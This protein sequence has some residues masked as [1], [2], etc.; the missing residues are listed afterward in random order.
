MNKEEKIKEVLGIVGLAIDPFEVAAF[1][2]EQHPFDDK[3]HRMSFL[4]K[5]GKIVKTS[6]M[7]EICE[8]SWRA[9]LQLLFDYIHPG[10]I[11]KWKV[12]NGF[13]GYFDKLEVKTNK[14]KKAEEEHEKT[15]KENTTKDHPELFQ[16]PFKKK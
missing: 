9:K 12:E 15:M 2:S 7:N 11:E 6:Y 5:S 1:E 3:R 4:M 14:L 13:T 10:E 16:N 8:R